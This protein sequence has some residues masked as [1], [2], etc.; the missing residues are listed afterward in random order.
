[1]GGPAVK[2]WLVALA[3]AAGLSVE[4]QPLT[5]G[6]LGRGASYSNFVP[7]AGCA[8]GYVPYFD[9]TLKLVCAPTVYAPSTDTTTFGTLAARNVTAI[10]L[11]A[12]GAVTVT[13]VLS[14]IGAITV[15]AGSA[16]ADGDALSVGDGVG[17]VPIEFDASPGDGTTGGAVPI[18]F[19]GT[20]TATEI[21]DAVKAILDGAGRDW[22]TSAQAANGIGLVRATPGATGGAITETVTNAGFSVTNWTPPAAATTY[23]YSLRACAADGA[24]TAAGA[25]S[26][27][28]AGVATLSALNHNALSW[29]AVTGAASY[30][31]YRTVGGATQGRIYAGAALAVNDTGLAGGGETAPTVDGTGVVTAGRVLAGDGTAA[32]PS[33]AW[34][35]DTTDGFYKSADNYLRWTAA[36]AGRLEIGTQI[37]LTDS[38]AIQFCAGSLDSARDLSLRRAAAATLQ[39]GAA[40]SATPVGQTLQAQ[41]SRG[42]TDTDVA[43]ANL[44]IRS[45]AGT[46]VATGS[47]L[48]FQTP[49]ATTTGSVAQTQV[50][51]L[52]LSVGGNYI[53]G[54]LYPS[55]ADTYALGIVSSAW[56]NL[57]LSRATLGSKSKA[58]VDATPT[59]VA[60]FTIADGATYGGKLIYNIV[61]TQGTAKQRLDGEARFSATREGSTYTVTINE[62]GTQTLAA[63]AG[64]LTGAM[65]IAGTGGV[66]TISANFNTSQTP[67]TFVCNLR[68]DSPDAALALTFP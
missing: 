29:S 58:I 17:V 52:V 65:Q 38:G 47:S 4:A 12:S 41:G 56:T 14:K 16:L 48:I 18:I 49:T 23:T 2:R 20:E 26:S 64:T 39:L 37:S 11:P 62:I 34:A 60:T 36:G 44:T 25:A 66:V 9:A 45:G 30:E 1:M 33:V 7:P 6:L 51:R 3:L 21:R 54:V 63:A 10:P 40:N 28:A 46:G 31:V 13:P 61:S 27:T 42:G 5:G 68:F 43:G 8:S 24:C 19:D 67:D 59:A 35:G 55:A 53:T 22:T 57:Y 32:A 15:V 50:N